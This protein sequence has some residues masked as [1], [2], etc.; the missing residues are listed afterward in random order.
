VAPFDTAAI[1][2]ARKTKQ[3]LKNFILVFPRK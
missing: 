1:L 3:Y 2:S